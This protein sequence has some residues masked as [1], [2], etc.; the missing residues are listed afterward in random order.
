MRNPIGNW[1][2]HLADPRGINAAVTI[3]PFAAD[4]HRGFERLLFEARRH[5]VHFVVLPRLAEMLR[6][7]PES[8]LRGRGVEARAEELVRQV[9]ALRLQDLAPVMAIAAVA[10]EVRAAITGMP[11]ILVKGLDFAEALFGGVANRA[12]G[13]IDLLYD[14]SAE[15][16]LRG[17]LKS[18]RFAEHAPDSH[19]EHYAERQWLRPH[20]HMD[21]VLLELHTDMVHTERLRRRISLPYRRYVAADNQVTPASRLILAAVH[22]AASHLFGRLQYVVDGLMASRAAVDADELRE[23]CSEVGALLP[24]RTLLRLAATIFAS[25]EAR[26]LLDALPAPRSGALESKLIS[27]DMVLAAKGRNRW[28]FIPQRRLYRR[29]MVS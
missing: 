27:A 3:E 11:V 8:V 9:S 20:P 24:L 1:L 10:H 7:E 17:R 13:D 12:F 5:S 16:D 6:A 29:L 25:E 4:D 14:R 18:L 28:R 21:H 26:T 19:P 22:A 23:R 2:A 15:A